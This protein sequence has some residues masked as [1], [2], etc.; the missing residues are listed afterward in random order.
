[1]WPNVAHA[2][3]YTYRPIQYNITLVQYFG[4]IDCYP[5][6]TI[7][8]LHGLIYVGLAHVIWATNMIACR[9]YFQWQSTYKWIYVCW[10]AHSLIFHWKTYHKRFVTYKYKISSIYYDS[11]MLFLKKSRLESNCCTDMQDLYLL[12]QTNLLQRCNRYHHEQ[13]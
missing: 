10:P 13:Y 7:P 5:Y 12:H 9:E 1:M 11:A 4:R 6:T 3:T 8:I 2:S